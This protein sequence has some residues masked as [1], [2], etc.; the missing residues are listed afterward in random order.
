MIR[1]YLS[2]YNCNCL[3]Y[4]DFIYENAWIFN[5]KDLYF[6]KNT[7]DINS[8]EGIIDI[9][10]F[11][12]L[13]K[14]KEGI[15]LNY[16]DTN[17]LKIDL[18]IE[19]IENIINKF[20][21]STNYF[22]ISFDDLV[23]CKNNDIKYFIQLINRINFL[24]S[25]EDENQIIMN[26]KSKELIYTIVFNK[27]LTSIKHLLNNSKLVLSTSKNLKIDNYILIQSD[28]FIIYY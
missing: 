9:K 15:N 23:N 6:D 22:Y 27:S 26:G 12:T 5:L 1:I 7:F 21:L 25:Y 2:S 17:L 13:L 18:S 16:I 4:L 19:S 11:P 10:Y 28:G 20:A 24:K 8:V 14:L 3:D